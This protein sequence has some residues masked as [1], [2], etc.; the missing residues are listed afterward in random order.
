MQPSLPPSP[1]PFP[2]GLALL[3]LCAATCLL[4]PCH[5]HAGPP[6][7]ASAKD[8]T[9]A[10]LAEPDPIFHHGAFDLQLMG[11]AVFSVQARGTIDRP[12]FDYAPIVLRLG[13]MV[14]NVYGQGFFRGNDEVMI[15]GIGAPVFSGPGSG[16][17]GLSLLY[18]RN[19]LAPNTTVVPYVTF[20]AGG[21]YNDVYH[22]HPQRIIGA[23]GEFDLQAAVGLRFRV[24]THLTLDTEFS[25]RHISNADFADRNY[26]TNG[27]GGMV[28]L[29]Y[30]F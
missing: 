11:G 7:T 22:E 23:A 28:G 16:L 19:F 20:G 2:S 15:E 14:N 12:N 18:R 9:P 10:A 21:V 5:L 30:G 1:L 8:T 17:G 4:L 6:D 24:S 25:Y 29:S 27:I 3:A 26:G 13:Y